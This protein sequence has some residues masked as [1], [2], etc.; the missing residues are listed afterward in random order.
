MPHSIVIVDDHTLIAE[1]LTGFI[2]EKFRNCKVLYNV[3]SGK[4]LIERF[5]EPKNI[6]D[7][8]LLDVDMPKINMDGFATAE[9]LTLHHPSVHILVLTGHDEE[10]TLMRMIRIGVKG[11]LLKNVFPDPFEKD[12][13]TIA[14]GGYVYPQSMAYKVLRNMA[15]DKLSSKSRPEINA[16]ELEFLEY[17]MTH[18][19]YKEIADK[20]CCSPRT[21]EGYRDN[22]FVKLGV[23][24]RVC[25]VLSALDYNLIKRNKSDHTFPSKN[26]S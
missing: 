3:D 23:K 6:P 9:W 12:L 5:R 20:M 26:S 8:V 18:L 1:V 25:L 24:T 4:A 7:I 15:D 13:E 19:T 21:V 22:L 17:A 10:E 2:T 11:Y 14:H 16:R